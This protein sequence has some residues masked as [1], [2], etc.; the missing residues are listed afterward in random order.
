MVRKDWLGKVRSTNL[1]FW[2]LLSFLVISM[3]QFCRILMKLI[4]VLAIFNLN[5]LGFWHDDELTFDIATTGGRLTEIQL[6]EIVFYHLIE[7][8]LIT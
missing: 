8:L 4:V 5:D 1:R 2:I 6:I 7:I 3:I